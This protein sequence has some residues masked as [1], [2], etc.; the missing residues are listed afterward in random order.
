M[1]ITIDVVMSLSVAN[2]GDNSWSHVVE[3]NLVRRLINKAPATVES[4][5]G[6]VRSGE[7][8]SE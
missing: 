4:N 1:V 3:R 5:G 7:F 8:Q 2:E 6:S